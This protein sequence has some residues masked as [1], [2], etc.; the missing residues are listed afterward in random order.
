MLRLWLA[1]SSGLLIA[2]D[3]R[4]QQVI[5]Q[6]D[7]A[8]AAVVQHHALS[9]SSQSFSDNNTLVTLAQKNTNVVSLLFRGHCLSGGK[10]GWMK[11]AE[12]EPNWS[13]TGLR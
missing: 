4:A 13:R 1:G 2:R 8:G 11:G 6:E 7:H 5:Q 12:L 10:E 9:Q 3:S